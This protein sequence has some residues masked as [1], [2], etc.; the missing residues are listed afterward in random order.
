MEGINLPGWHFHFLSQDKTTGGHILG[1]Q[2]DSLSLQLNP[3][4]DWKLL[5]ENPEFASRDL[6]EDLSAKTAAAVEGNAKH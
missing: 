1:L 5:P 6:C 4:L 3:I 2:A